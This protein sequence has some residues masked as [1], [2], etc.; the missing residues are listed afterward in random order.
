[1][2]V[3]VGSLAVVA[4]LG[5]M[6]NA[7]LTA[8]HLRPD[9]D[10]ASVKRVIN[11]AYLDVARPSTSRRRRRLSRSRRDSR[12]T[13]SRTTSAS[14]ISSPYRDDHRAGEREPRERHDGS[15]VPE[16]LLAMRSTTTV[17]SDAPWMF[18]LYGIDT[19]MVYPG[20]L[21]RGGDAVLHEA[22][23]ALYDDSDEPELLPRDLHWVVEERAVELAA[24]RW[25]RNS[26]LA[27]DAHA[28]YRSVSARRGRGSRSGTVSGRRRSRRCRLSTLRVAGRADRSTDY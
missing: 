18:A 27:A 4:N 9:S 6:T 22:A 15:D 5:E 13:P 20:P 25:A 21:E 11:D 10:R 3:A 28:R 2:R 8:A 23:A 17:S 19:L 24:S 26:Q 16:R 14:T 7:V 12:T 1:M